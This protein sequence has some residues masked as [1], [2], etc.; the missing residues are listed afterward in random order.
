VTVTGQNLLAQCDLSAPTPAEHGSVCS[1]SRKRDPNDVIDAF[2]GELSSSLALWTTIRASLGTT[3]EIAK[4]VSVDAFSRAAVAFE[5]F[6]SDWHIAA[7]NR[8][9][10]ALRAFLL[11]S[12]Q[13]QVQGRFP[14]L[15]NR[16]QVDL[17]LHPT[18]QDV[19]DLLDPLGRNVSLPDMASWK[20]RANEHL[21]N[22]WKAKLLGLPG[23][24]EKLVDAVI[25]VRNL[26]AHESVSATDRMN[27]AL[28]NLSGST[29]GAL[30]GGPQRIT[31]SGVGSYLNAL[32]T[33]TARVERYHRRRDA[34]VEKLRV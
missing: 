19:T 15:V 1:V 29:D 16:V 6:R 13:A 3:G 25:A 12:V 26:L 2:Q 21:M 30:K 32:T 7:I 5:G 17:P 22:P 31:P 33:G 10:T 27:T 14:A 34:I 28:G 4:R 11:S 9:S 8:D 20:A 18:L 24:D 23:A